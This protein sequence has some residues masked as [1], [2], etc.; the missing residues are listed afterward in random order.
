MSSSKGQPIRDEKALWREDGEE[1][2]VCEVPDQDPAG[3]D[4]RRHQLCNELCNKVL[5]FVC[6]VPDQD[7]A[8]W[9]FRRHQLCNE[10]C[11]KVLLFGKISASSPFI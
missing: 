5:L 10:L 7:P 6:E 9:D 4:F 1:V 11:N 2:F 3:W 8:G